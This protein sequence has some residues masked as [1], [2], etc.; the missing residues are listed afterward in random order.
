MFSIVHVV[1]ASENNVIGVNGDLPWHIPEDL[2][3]FKDATV[4]KPIIMGRKTF[5]S[6]PNKK[7]LPKRL[8]IV[9]TRQDDY[10]AENAHVFKSLEEAIEF[11]K[12]QKDQYGEELCI[13]GG[14]EIFTQSLEITQKV[15]L[16]RVHTDIK[17]GDAFYPEL[18]EHFEKIE[19][20]KK[21]QEDGLSYSFETF[22]NK[23]A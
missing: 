17:N 19:S 21:T 14:G 7:G 2:Q 22:V 12:S 13:I 15:Y 20:V 18:P 4:H 8:N 3:F 10:T 9:I 5:E 6:L 16:T 1:A 23:K 11:A